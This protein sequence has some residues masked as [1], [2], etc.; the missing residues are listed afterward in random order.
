LERGETKVH[1]M[2]WDKLLMPNGLEGMGFRDLQLFNQALLARQP[3]RV[4]QFL[5]SICA[6]LLRAKYYT[7]GEL[8]DMVFLGD[9]PPTW[10][11]I[12]HGLTLVKKG[13]I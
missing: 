10:R 7:R 3:W 1:W 11:A 5:E 12:E 6:R 8:I 13:I 2:A 9:A 4:I